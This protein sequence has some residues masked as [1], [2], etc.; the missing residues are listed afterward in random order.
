MIY[1]VP[2]ACVLLLLAQSGDSYLMRN[3]L[4]QQRTQSGVIS[5]LQQQGSFG[6]RPMHTVQ[7]WRLSATTNHAT[8][9]KKVFHPPAGSH[10]HLKQPPVWTF[11]KGQK[12]GNFG[13]LKQLLG[14]K[15]ANLADMSAIGLSVP[16]GFTITT[17]VCAAFHKSNSVL[18]SSVWPE[19]LKGVQS[20]ENQMERVF[21]DANRPLLVSVRSGAAISMPGMMDTILNLGINDETVVGLAK[22][23]GEKFALDSYRRFLQ[24]FGNVVMD[25][26]SHDFEHVLTEVKHQTGAKDDAALT[27]DALRL[28]VTKFK[29]VYTK[30][31]KEFLTDPYAQLHAAVLAV[32]N[33]WNSDRAIKYRE[34]EGITGLLGT[35]VNVQ[36]MVFGNM[37]ETSGT[38]VCF[39]RNPNTGENV[40]YGEYLIN[41]QGEDVVAGIRTP[42]PIK[43]LHDTLP[44][45]YDELVRNVAT[46]ESHYHDMQ[47]IEFTIQEGKLFMLQTR[48]GKR[49]GP[50]AVKIAT[51][52]VDEGLATP[53]QAIMMVKPEHLNQLLHPQ[54]TNSVK[55]KVYKDH[56]LAKGLPASPGAAVGKIV[57]SPEDAEKAKAAGEKCILVRDETSP[58]DVGGMWAAEGVLTA[59]G[60]MTSHAAVVAR[61]WGKPCVCGCDDLKIN[62]EDGTVTFY[63]KNSDVE[64]VT[65]HEGDMISLNGDTG[66]IIQGALPLHPPSIDGSEDTVRL[67]KWVDEKRNIRVMANADTPEDAAEARR[68]GAQGIGLTRT[69]HMF[70]SEDR[71]RVVRRMILSKDAAHR[72]RA[73]AELLPYQRSDFEGILAAMDNLPVTI[74]LLDP[75]LHEFLPHP[76]DVDA[77]FAA[78]VG[79]TVE[80]CRHAIE[81]L[82][83]VNPM[84]GM[85]GCRLGVVMPELIVMQ[86]R[87]LIEATW[88]N[89]YVKGL[90]PKP[91]IMIPLVGSASEFLHQAKLI[92]QGAEEVF[93]EKPVGQRVDY[94]LGTM[95]EVP[96]AALVAKELAEA[97]AEFFSYG[98]NDLTQMTYGFSR[99]DVGSFLPSY[100]KQ[101][102][103][104]SDPFE[105]IDTQ[106]VGSLISSSA[107][108]GREVAN[109][110][111]S[112]FK[113][114][115]CGEHGGDPKSVRFFVKAGL[116]YVSCSPF[117]VP[118]ARLAAAQ[119]AIEM[120]R[121]AAKN[122]K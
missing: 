11:G 112:F 90:N 41:A 6:L 64:A 43:K 72:A 92:R 22:D 10:V 109:A 34:A 63:P 117:R 25:I 68:N 7:G 74:R 97:G 98:T 14:G 23:F 49:V 87:A 60:G 69:E 89:K 100:L 20:I 77:S 46:L 96:R 71:I 53:E 104:E 33:S 76:K 75:P 21:G 115:V 116:D 95:I 30:H 38:G 93:A 13:D 28:I 56:V 67:M 81:R 55:D 88:N 119:S 102:L 27:P 110:K 18:P 106:G 52:M 15:G 85:R 78:D 107:K 108:V 51:S 70:F 57:F 31:G 65:L 44:H 86:A 26:P 121:E 48:S 16:P 50:A 36:A 91:E 105:T 12:P 79:M 29:D 59:R 122:K 8:S 103:L 54:F 58:E 4:Y 9:H 32:F 17:E 61:G 80:E 118:V 113:A 24:M 45:A 19:V 84:L 37:G 66:E 73:L 62:Y 82:E 99:D 2:I 5:A 39:S 101:G 1:T 83:E 3:G 47:D 94:K 35:A 120:E 42:L 111:Q 40:L 114:G